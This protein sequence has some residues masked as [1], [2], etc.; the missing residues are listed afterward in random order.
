MASMWKYKPKLSGCAPPQIDT[1]CAQSEQSRH[2]DLLKDQ[3][4]SETQKWLICCWQIPL[5]A[6]FLGQWRGSQGAIVS[7]T[8]LEPHTSTA[9]Q[10][11]K[12]VK[13]LAAA[14]AY[15]RSN[16]RADSST[17]DRMRQLP[18]RTRR[19]LMKF[20]G[21]QILSI[22]LYKLLPSYFGHVYKGA[23][24]QPAYHVRLHGA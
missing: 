15:C 17:D 20:E 9:F 21:M 1:M 14:V 4:L 19:W 11:C 12:S 24:C 23:A 16:S 18:M 3:W 7:R 8:L 10:V 2:R 6:W 22:R 13:A 5:S